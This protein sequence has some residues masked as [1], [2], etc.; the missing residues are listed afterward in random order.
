MGGR[1]D[2]PGDVKNSDIP[3][4]SHEVGSVEALPP[5]EERKNSWKDEATEEEG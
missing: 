1:V 4:D 2:K 3:E 5:E